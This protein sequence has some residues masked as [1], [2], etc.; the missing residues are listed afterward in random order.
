M[1]LGYLMGPAVGRLDLPMDAVQLAESLGFDSIWMSEAY[2]ADV[3]SPVSWRSP[4]ASPSNPNK[5][6]RYSPCRAC[7]R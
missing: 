6:A 7:R 3:V 1:K 4:A 2:G 5:A